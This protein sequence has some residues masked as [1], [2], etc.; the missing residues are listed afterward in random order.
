MNDRFPASPVTPA[1]ALLAGALIR[2]RDTQP[3]PA[4][5]DFFAI[6]ATGA[7]L[8]SAIAARIGAQPLA[9]ALDELC[10]TYYPALDELPDLITREELREAVLGGIYAATAQARVG[11]M[12]LVLG[13]EYGIRALASVHLAAAREV[14]AAAHALLGEGRVA[15]LRPVQD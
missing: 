13:I 9:E 14:A 3:S 8:R 1:F 10:S 12:S 5:H 4:P 11:R 15:R 6:L 7:S 2:A